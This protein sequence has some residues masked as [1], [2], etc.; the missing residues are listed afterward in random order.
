MSD[1]HNMRFYARE[2][3]NAHSPEKDPNFQDTA[4]CNDRLLKIVEKVKR[5]GAG[6]KAK[7]RE[8]AA[9]A[10]CGILYETLR[11]VDSL[12]LDDRIEIYFT[13][14]HE[15]RMKNLE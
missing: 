8:D 15:E 9:V 11:L 13:Q 7:D 3:N 5:L 10:A 4:L 2:Y 6:I 1:T 12:D 14:Y